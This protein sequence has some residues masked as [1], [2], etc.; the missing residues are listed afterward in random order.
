M[1]RVRTVKSI[2]YD[3]DSTLKEMVSLE[4][5]MFLLE[6]ET[7]RSVAAK[8]NRGKTTVAYD[9]KHR[10]YLVEDPYTVALVKNKLET[11]KELAIINATK[12]RFS[13]R[14]NERYL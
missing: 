5:E 8:L 4:A 12:A 13:A 7:T 10:M 3:T 11:N 9:L 14:D 1:P 6:G 2:N